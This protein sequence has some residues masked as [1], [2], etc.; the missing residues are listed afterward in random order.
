MSTTKIFISDV[1]I[2]AGRYCSESQDKSKYPHDWD[3]LSKGEK[4]N[5]IRFLDYLPTR[6]AANTEVVLLGDIF[7]NWIFPHDLEPPTIEDVIGA[8]ENQGVMVALKT[9]SEKLN[10][11]YVPGNHDMHADRA[12]INAHF[13]RVRY[14]AEQYHSERLIAEHGHRYA[15]FNAPPR[16]SR[17]ISGLPLGYFISRMEA[18]RKA[19]YNNGGRHYKTYVDDFLEILGKATLSQ[20]VFE[21]V[22]EETKLSDNEVFVF[23]NYSGARQTVDAETIKDTYANLYDDWNSQV[24]SRP[25][26]VM[27]ELDRLEPIADRLCKHGKYKVCI[28][29]HSHK[30]DVDVDRAFVDDRVYANA[31]YWCGAQCTFVEVNLTGRQYGVSLKQWNANGTVKTLVPTKKV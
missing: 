19:R 8:D 4:E 11:F 7:D 3:W 22:L 12:V 15:L 24:I 10:V 31:G 18:T 9:L 29:G 23:R 27:A 28:M 2:G 6:Y 25:R 30:F 5:F 16:F 13:P 17:N 20:G 21:A 26:A 1:H 14:V